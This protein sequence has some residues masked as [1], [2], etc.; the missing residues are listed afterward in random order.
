MFTFISTEGLKGPRCILGTLVAEMWG[1]TEKGEEGWGGG[2]VL[3]PL[4]AAAASS[5][6]AAA[7]A[8]LQ[9]WEGWGAMSSTEFAG[10]NGEPRCQR[11]S[12]DQG[13]AV[14]TREHA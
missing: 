2:V 5:G 3:G 12:G 9:R 1:P 4:Y 7:T 13:F 14:N 10:D 11:W 8:P 6:H